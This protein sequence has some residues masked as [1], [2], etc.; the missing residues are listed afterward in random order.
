LHSLALKLQ[1]LQLTESKKRD[2]DFS[3]LSKKLI[4]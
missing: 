2:R 3:D 1:K 4:K